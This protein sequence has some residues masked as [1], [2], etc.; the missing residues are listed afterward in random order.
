MKLNFGSK[1]L[2]EEANQSLM[3]E[4]EI[5]LIDEAKRVS[6]S[7]NQKVLEASRDVINMTEQ[8]E[9]GIYEADENMF[10]DLAE[11]KCFLS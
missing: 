7:V 9:N 4:K 1:E 5:N 6:E 8:V 10:E 2:R 11:E 3:E